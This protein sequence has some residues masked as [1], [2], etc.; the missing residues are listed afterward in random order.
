MYLQSYDTFWSTS[1][2]YFIVTQLNYSFI[3]YYFDKDLVP[4]EIDECNA[5]QLILQYSTYIGLSVSTI[6]LLLTILVYLIQI[7]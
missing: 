4:S 6:G 1:G 3:V 7:R 2:M 5:C